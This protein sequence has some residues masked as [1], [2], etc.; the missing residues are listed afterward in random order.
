MLRSKHRDS[1]YLWIIFLVFFGYFLL[2]G[3]VSTVQAEE[4]SSCV[5][6]HTDSRELIKLS[7]IILKMRPP[8]KSEEIKGEG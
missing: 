5:S 8:V 4:K 1:W 3:I 7:R 6:C 2:W